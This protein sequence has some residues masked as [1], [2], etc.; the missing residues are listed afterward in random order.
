VAEYPALVRAMFD[1]SFYPHPVDKVELVQTQMS[2]VF[3]AGEYVYK[4]KKPVNLGYLDYTTL[5]KRRFFCGQEIELNRRLAH[6]V[7]LAVLPITATGAGFSLGG[8]G[9]PVEYTVKM[10]R[11][12]PERMMNVLLPAGQITVEMV[13]RLSEKLA[14]FHEKAMTNSEISAFGSL[15]S[16]RVNIDENFSQT[17]KYRGVSIEAAD[18]DRIRAFTEDFVASKAALF[19]ERL[20]GGRIRDCHGD[21]HA[22]HICFTDGIQIYDCIEFNERFRYCDVASE[23]AFLAMDLD[24]YDRGDLSREFVDAYI[25]ASSD[26]A[27]QQ[28]LPFYKCYRAYVR[29]KVESFKLDD[30]YISIEEKQ[31]TLGIARGYFSLARRYTMTEPVLLITAGLMGTGKTTIAEAVGRKTGAIVISSDVVRKRLAG[32]RPGE[33][34]YEAFENGIYSADFTRKTYDALYAEAARLLAQGRSVILDASFKKRN[35]RLRAAEVAVKAGARFMVVECVLDEATVRERLR[36][37]VLDGTSASD[38]REEILGAQ[39]ADFDTIAEFS[40]TSHIVVETSRPPGD[41]ANLIVEKAW[42]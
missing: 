30:P 37:R 11:L 13:G 12:P 19:G 41:I 15:E 28:L 40:K 1:P 18:Y 23:I 8:Q 33:R 26:A 3:L 17:V 36:K 20:R 14:R 38:G 34:H 32:I 5:E 27:I 21:L 9:P 25:S 29:G 24:R 42:Q 22:A 39:K 35:E 7:Y 4:V 16:I 31:K 10:R 6:D 2:F